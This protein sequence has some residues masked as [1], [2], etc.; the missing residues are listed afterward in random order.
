MIAFVLDTSAVIELFVRDETNPELR[1]R[2]LTGSGVAPELIDLESANVIRRMVL[3]RELATA[4][5]R[6]ALGEIRESP[7]TRIP[8]R[9]L[10]GRVW[11]LRDTLTAYDA[12]YVALAELF[13]VPILTCDGRLARSHGHD[14]EIELYARA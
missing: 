2:V 14:A 1:R 12:A 6:E 13:G 9:P 3:C 8:H 11:E 10:I 5:A 4:E 7:L